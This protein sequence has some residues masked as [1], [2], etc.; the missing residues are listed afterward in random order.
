MRRRSPRRNAR[1]RRRAALPANVYDDLDPGSFDAVLVADLAPYV[2]APQ[3]LAELARLVAPNGVLLGG[4]RNPGRARALPAGGG[5]GG[6]TA[7]LRAA[8]GRARPALS[9]GGGGHPESGPRLPAGLRHQRGTAGR[10]HARRRGRVGLLRRLLQPAAAA[11]DR[12]HLGPAAARAAGLHPRQARGGRPP[13]Q[14]VGGALGH[15]EAGAG[16]GERRAAGPRGTGRVPAARAGAGPRV[17]RRPHRAA[18][19]RAREP[20]PCAGEGRAHLPPE[21]HRGRAPGR[22]RAGGRCR[23][24]PLAGSRDRRGRSQG[25]ERARGRGPGGARRWSAG[26]GAARGDRGPARGRP[27]APG[28]GLRERT[29]APGR[30]RLRPRGARAQPPRGASGPGGRARGAP[31]R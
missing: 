29:P 24:A 14:G 30:G 22:A 28:D 4:L 27:R 11:A 25:E 16:E 7:H 23:A 20:G 12:S 6:R 3:L 26:A 13:Q 5:G 31:A 2:R 1:T 8:A 15:A 10:R 9:A 21:A 17:R 18:G 19:C